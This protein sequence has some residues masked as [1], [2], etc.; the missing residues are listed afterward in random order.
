MALSQLPHQAP[1][2][3]RLISDEGEPEVAARMRV[4]NARFHRLL[5][6]CAGILGE[7]IRATEELSLRV[8][9]LRKGVESRAGGNESRR[10]EEK[11]S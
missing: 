5:D 7:S 2:R 3:N 11:K 9:S 4:A 1:Q 8:S 6:Y 10:R